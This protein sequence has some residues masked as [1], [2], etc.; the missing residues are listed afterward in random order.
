MG[1]TATTGAT[2]GTTTTRP[3]STTTT[4]GSTRTTNSASNSSTGNSMSNDMKAPNLNVLQR[5]FN[6]TS[7][8]Y[9]PYLMYEG[10]S[11]TVFDTNKYTTY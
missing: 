4:N 11:N 5:D 9:S 1:S 3:A 10:F 7:N 2:T 6:G 8:V